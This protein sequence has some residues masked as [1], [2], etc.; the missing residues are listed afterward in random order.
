MGDGLHE[1]VPASE[2]TDRP[3][4]GHVV[5]I[6][7]DANSRWHRGERGTVT[8]DNKSSSYPF[9]VRFESGKQDTFREKDVLGYGLDE[10]GVNLWRCA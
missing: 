7:G 8:E 3:Q 1:P 4:V 5:Q 9:R 6:S 2:L 10:A